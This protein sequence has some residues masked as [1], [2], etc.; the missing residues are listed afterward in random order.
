MI[1]P[2]KIMSEFDSLPLIEFLSIRSKKKSP[3]R[4]YLFA[5]QYIF[6]Y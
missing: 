5:N 2:I 6:I 1:S 3:K 4:L